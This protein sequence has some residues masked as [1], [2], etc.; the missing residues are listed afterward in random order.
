M[1]T[2]ILTYHK[3]GLQFYDT[4]T[5]YHK[6]GLQVKLYVI[7]NWLAKTFHSWAACNIVVKIANAALV[8]IPSLYLFSEESRMVA[9]KDLN[10]PSLVHESDVLPLTHT[11]SLV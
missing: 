5:T 1:Q 7:Y 2:N 3:I 4:F 8:T 11:E 9:E 10:L 6:I